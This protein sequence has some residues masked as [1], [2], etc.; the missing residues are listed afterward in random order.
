MR[1]G[2]WYDRL[3]YLVAEAQ[4]LVLGVLFSLGAALVIF[5]PSI[6]QVPPVAVGMLAATML[7]GPALFGFFVWF[8]K[9]LRTRNMVEVHHVNAVNDDLEKFYVEPSVWAEKSIEGPNPYP[10][11]GGS[12]WAVQEFEWLEDVG[13]LRV[14]GV[15]LEEVAD[16]KLLTSKSHM[17]AIYGKLTE[18]HIALN[19]LR[20]SVS[21]FGADIQRRLVN[22]MAEAR[23]RGKMM[24]QDA[25]KD[26]FE[27]FEDDA[28]GLGD[29]DLPTLE[30]DEVPGGDRVGDLEDEAMDAIDTPADVGVG[31]GPQEAATDGG[32]E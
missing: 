14:K 12:A 17:E 21:E 11:N 32:Q 24:D 16:T 6:P 22:S 26:V 15:W 20:D 27:D 29:D 10:V 30:P 8:V 23:E 2:N 7:F 4:I 18:S 31:S 19:I 9:K 28:T 3:T 1:F 5:R 13:E 25:V